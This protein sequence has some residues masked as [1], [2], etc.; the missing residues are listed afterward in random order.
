ASTDALHLLKQS[1][2]A[3]ESKVVAFS[4]SSAALLKQARALVKAAR[5]EAN[6]AKAAQQAESG[7]L[8]KR[9]ARGKKA[10]PQAPSWLAFTLPRWDCARTGMCPVEL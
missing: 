9:T 5:S 2:L 10:G 1:G 8:S 3:A 4:R 7:K 6:V